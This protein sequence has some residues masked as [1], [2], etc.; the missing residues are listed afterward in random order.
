M[1]LVMYPS[2]KIQIILGATQVKYTEKNL[3]S[4][5]QIITHKTRNY[6][7]LYFIIVLLAPFVIVF[8]CLSLVYIII[9]IYPHLTFSFFLNNKI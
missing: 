7:S 9:I 6:L 2:A 5:P 3:F 8:L 4:L 1:L